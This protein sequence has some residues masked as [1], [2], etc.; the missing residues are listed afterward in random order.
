M[1]IITVSRPGKYGAAKIYIVGLDIFTGQKHEDIFR[2]NSAVFPL[3]VRA[4]YEVYGV[5]VS[6][7]GQADLFN[8]IEGIERTIA[9]PE[10]EL[11]DQMRRLWNEGIEFTVTI[12]E[13]YW[14]P[15]NGNNVGEEEEQAQQ[16]PQ[17][18]EERITA[19]LQKSN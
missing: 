9:I 3:I 5:D 6:S 11:G 8:T 17:L 12:T 13:A 18:I 10:G 7:E 4:D 2:Y 15:T 16:K 19:V 1:L 14:N